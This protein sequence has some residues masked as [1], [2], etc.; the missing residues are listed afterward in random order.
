[1]VNLLVDLKLRLGLEVFPHGGLRLLPG[2]HG[3]SGEHF[4]G[5]IFDDSVENYA[6]AAH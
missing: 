3:R 5:H 1:M 2:T 4:G 6:V